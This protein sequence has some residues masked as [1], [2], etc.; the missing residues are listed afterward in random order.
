MYKSQKLEE[1]L[2]LSNKA[3]SVLGGKIDKIQEFELK[4]YSSTR[5]IL[6]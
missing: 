4:Q 3:I 2:S 5:N 1:E 6:Y